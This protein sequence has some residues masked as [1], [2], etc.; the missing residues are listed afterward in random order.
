M[1][2]L[3]EALVFFLPCSII[4]ICNLVTVL[5]VDSKKK[6]K[7]VLQIII[8]ENTRSIGN[9]GGESGNNN[10]NNDVDAQLAELRRMMQT[11][12]GTMQTQQQILQAQQQLFQAH[13]VQ[14]QPVAPQPRTTNP[15]EANAGE[16]RVRQEGHVQLNPLGPDVA[17]VKEFLNLK[18]PTYEGGMNAVR[19]KEWLSELEKNF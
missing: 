10:N 17:L 4:A 14:P 8:M 12:V 6:K 11:L 7:I 2:F 19:A 15:E 5:H 13:L 1:A 16:E 18:P 3:S 9:E